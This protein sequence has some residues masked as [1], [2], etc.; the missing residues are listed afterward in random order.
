MGSRWFVPLWRR[1]FFVGFRVL[2]RLQKV[3]P[4]VGNDMC[5]ARETDGLNHLLE[6]CQPEIKITDP[7]RFSARFQPSI[8]V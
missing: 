7:N 3:F 1:R 2:D 8:Q 4:D 6:H 5:V